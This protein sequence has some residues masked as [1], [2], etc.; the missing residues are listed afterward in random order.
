M[1][2][3]DAKKS[4]IYPILKAHVRSTN[5]WFMLLITSSGKGDFYLLTKLF[6]VK[7]FIKKIYKYNL[8]GLFKIN[9][10]EFYNLLINLRVRDLGN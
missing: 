10:T 1:K 4:Q 6:D 3:K 7:I 5:N 8:Q 9:S 2:H